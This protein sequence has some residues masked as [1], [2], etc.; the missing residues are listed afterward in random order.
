MNKG[1][2]GLWKL[3]LSCS[4]IG[5]KEETK[6]LLSCHFGKKVTSYNHFHNILRL[7]NVLPNFPV[8]RLEAM[9]TY[10]TL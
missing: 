3:N 8:T 9:Y 4:T 2:K 5:K 6:S 10:S 1:T 7:F